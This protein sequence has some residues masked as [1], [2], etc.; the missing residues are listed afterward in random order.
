[1]SSSGGNKIDMVDEDNMKVCVLDV[2]IS[3]TCVPI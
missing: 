1:M 3:F 2:P